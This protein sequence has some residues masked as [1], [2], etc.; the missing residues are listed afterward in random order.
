MKRKRRTRRGEE[1]GASAK[2][3]G[4][5]FLV[6]RPALETIAAATNDLR[7]LPIVEIGSGRGALTFLL[8]ERFPS[9]IAVEKDERLADELTN[10]LRERNINAVTVVRGDILR[11]FPNHLALP[12]RYAVIANIPYYLTSRLIRTLLESKRRPEAMVLMVQEEV[13]ERIVAKPPRMN[14][15]GLAVQAYATPRIIGRIPRSA[16]QPQPQVDS[17]IV[18]MDHISDQFFR[19]NRIAPSAFFAMLRAA[20]SGKRKILANSLGRLAGGKTKAATAIAAAGI[21]PAARP[22]TLSLPDWTRLS[23]A[24]IAEQKPA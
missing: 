14:L 20:F 9:V 12:E 23:H 3:L 4:Q 5:H 16:F 22:E 10:V 13:A 7:K 1:N 24:L 11:I 18:R 15:L 21:P 2:R 19:A 8:A 6:S 17:A